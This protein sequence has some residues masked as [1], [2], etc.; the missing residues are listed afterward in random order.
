MEG[1]RRERERGEGIDRW[2]REKREREREG[3]ERKGRRTEREKRKLWISTVPASFIT[4]EFLTST[5]PCYKTEA[6]I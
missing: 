1:G 6:K 3:A 5:L 2:E 4:L